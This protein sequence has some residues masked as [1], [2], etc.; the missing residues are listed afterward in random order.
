MTAA[1]CHLCCFL[2]ESHV[3]IRSL[4]SPQGVDGLALLYG[5]GKV[6]LCQSAWRS[7]WEWEDLCHSASL[8]ATRAGGLLLS[9]RPEEEHVSFCQPQWAWLERNRSR[10][11]EMF[12]AYLETSIFYKI[13]LQVYCSCK[14]NRTL[15]SDFVKW[16]YL[17]GM[18]FYKRCPFYSSANINSCFS[19]QSKLFPRTTRVSEYTFMGSNTKLELSM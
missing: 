13:L 6:V 18:K 4:L 11:E 12:Y 10:W 7:C 5:R 19:L 1:I 3:L 8:A 9:P 16:A 2:P 14:S 15:L 17:Y